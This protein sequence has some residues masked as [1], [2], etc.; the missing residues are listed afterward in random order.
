M[1]PAYTRIQ[2]RASSS[3]FRVPDT[4]V[5]THMAHTPAFWPKPPNSSY[6]NRLTV[7]L[8]L[9]LWPK[10]V[11][12]PKKKPSTPRATLT[13]VPALELWQK[14][15]RCRSSSS[16]IAPKKRLQKPLRKGFRL[17][18]KIWIMLPRLIYAIYW[19]PKYLTVC[20]A[21]WSQLD[22]C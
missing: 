18:E 12:G 7:M 2:H 13:T 9:W 1:N 5:H 6:S 4:A 21:G 20:S 22:S 17:H 10:A 14:G 8:H 15:S 11:M 16:K 19:W 3:L